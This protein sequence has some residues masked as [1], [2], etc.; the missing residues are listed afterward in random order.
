MES[1]GTKIPNETHEN[2]PFFNH[3]GPNRNKYIAWIRDKSK[4]RSKDLAQENQEDEPSTWMKREGK[5]S[6]SP[7][8]IIYLLN[9]F[10]TL[11]IMQSKSSIEWLINCL[12]I[13]R[14]S[15]NIS[16]LDLYPSIEAN[17]KKHSEK[18]EKET[19]R[20]LD[21]DLS[22]EKKAVFDLYTGERNAK[23][24]ACMYV[25]NDCK[26]CASIYPSPPSVR[27]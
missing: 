1:N 2:I 11:L 23:T 10:L 15:G 14:W 27:W 12:T 17:E 3:F 6:L 4:G 21:C 5:R 13:I 24:Y 8:P 19:P 26:P 22:K 18:D 16:A 25:R 7:P 20:D 9:A